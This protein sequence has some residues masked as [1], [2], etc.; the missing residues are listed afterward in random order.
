M[1][2]PIVLAWLAHTFIDVHLTLDSLVTWCTCAGVEPNMIIAQ[3]PVLARVWITFIYFSFTVH[4]FVTKQRNILLQIQKSVSA[5]WTSELESQ[6]PCYQPKLA[7]TVICSN[8][9]IRILGAHEQYA[10]LTN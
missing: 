7:S 6:K 3:G 2:C 10:I 8:F 5:A 4:T 1:T 9:A